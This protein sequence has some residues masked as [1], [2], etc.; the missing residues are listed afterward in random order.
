M[1]TR[2]API[3]RPRSA[4]DAIAGA[5]TPAR[6]ASSDGAGAAAREERR[7]RDPARLARQ[8]VS[9]LPARLALAEHFPDVASWTWYP[10]RDRL[11]ASAWFRQLLGRPAEEPVTIGDALA[12]MP[13]EDAA[14]VRSVLRLMLDDGVDSCSVDYRLRSRD[15]STHWL[16]GYCMALRDAHGA[17]EK[18]MGLSR[19]VTARVEATLDAVRVQQELASARDYLRAVT[20]TMYEPMVT[21]DRNGLVEYV[22]PAAERVLGYSCG[23]LAGKLMQAVIQNERADGSIYPMHECPIMTARAE[24][25]AVEVDED[26]F[27]RKDGTHIPVSYSALPFSADAGI[28]GCVVIFE[29]VAAR[30]AERRRA[31]REEVKLRWAR[32]IRDALDEGRFELYC[33]PIVDCASGRVVQRE[34]LLRLNDPQEGVIAPASFLP[35]AEELGLIREIDRWVVGRAVEI[36]R[37]RGAVEVN[38]SARSIGHSSLVDHIALAIER[39]GVDPAQLVFEITETA[40][41]EDEASARSFLERLHSLGCKIALDDFGTGYGSFTYLKRLPVDILKID[42]EF[43]RDLG[44]DAR[45]RSVVEAVVGLARGFGLVTVGEGVEDRGTFETL[46]SL[47]VDHAQGF[48]LGR[49]YPPPEH[50]AAR[51]PGGQAAARASRQHAA[52]RAPV[53]PPQPVAQPVPGA[54]REGEVSRPF[55]PPERIEVAQVTRAIARSREL[56]RRAATLRADAMR[57]ASGGDALRASVFEES[58]SRTVKRPSR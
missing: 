31:A 52:A 17:V 24:G 32:R 51:G 27:I 28:E 40:L 41:I 26:T 49:P 1:S 6:E 23:E 25:R 43:V 21:L 45:N 54:P 20:D 48:H 53:A 50:A 15:G 13:A 5:A 55:L 57:S 18:V 38:L 3:T 36:A 56:R 37:E 19:D 33:Q 58:R 44:E 12:A 34:L 4:R 22:N 47:G 39:E 7:P 2:G 8:P 30:K 42:A 11:H 35:A 9:E 46:A 29:A 10:A 14:A 16:E